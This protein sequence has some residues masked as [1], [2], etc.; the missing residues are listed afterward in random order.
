MYRFFLNRGILFFS[1]AAERHD[2]NHVWAHNSVRKTARDK[3]RTPNER[4]DRACHLVIGIWYLVENDCNIDGLPK[5]WKNWLL[6]FLRITQKVL[7]I[8]KGNWGQIKAKSLAKNYCIK[9]LNYVLIF[10][11]NGKWFFSKCWNGVS[12]ITVNFLKYDF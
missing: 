12:R 2:W 5:N 4:I 3:S 11:K 9:R 10:R 8:S 1:A 6:V 7:V